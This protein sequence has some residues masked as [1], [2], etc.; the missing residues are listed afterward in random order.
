MDLKEI[1]ICTRNWVD[2]AQ[3]KEYWRTLVN[4]ALNLRVP[5]NIIIIFDIQSK[6]VAR[7]KKARALS[8]FKQLYLK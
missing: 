1:D 2:S 8:K 6:Y 4:V 3:D 5:L 7:S